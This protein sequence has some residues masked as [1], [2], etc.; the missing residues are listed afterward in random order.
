[1]EKTLKETLLEALE[2]EKQGDW[3]LAHSIV[4]N[5][6]HP[7]ACRIHAY[8]HRKEPD[9]GNARYWYHCAGEEMSDLS[10]EEEWESI[11]KQIKNT[12]I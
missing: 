11:Y 8:L 9:P 4:Q 2:T 5:L 1:M 7:L 12:N 3:D 6:E 10:F